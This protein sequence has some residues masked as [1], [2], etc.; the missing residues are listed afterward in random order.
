[1][2]TSSEMNCSICN[3]SVGLFRCN[4]CSANFCFEHVNQHKINFEKQLNDLIEQE[5][6][7][8]KQISNEN[9]LFNQIDLWKKENIN[10]IKSI[11]KQTKENLKEIIS[12][13]NEILLNKSKQIKDKLQTI[14]QSQQLAEKNLK[15][16]QFDLDNLKNEIDSFE[17]IQ[18]NNDLQL[19]IEI[20]SKSQID[21]KPKSNE[22]NLF[23]SNEIDEKKE[24]HLFIS[25]IDPYGHFIRIE[26]N[27]S[28]K[29]DQDLL[30]WNIQR[31]IDSYQTI[32]FTFQQDFILKSNSSM[33]ILSK[34]ASQSIYSYETENVVI[35]HSIPSWGFGIQ[36]IVNTLSDPSGNQLHIRR[37][38]FY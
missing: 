10:R 36:T 9:I 28:I 24:G 1:M 2:T 33:K 17:L 20:K 5:S 32:S 19:K 34:Q 11:A 12:K 22:E 16:I 14:Q 30:G 8:E 4:D 7:F 31:Q 25:E 15:E 18:S 6:L 35:A 37:Q 38:N 21:S 26:H 23:K 3:E 29:K 27:G 13:S